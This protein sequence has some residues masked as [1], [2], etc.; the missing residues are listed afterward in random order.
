VHKTIKDMDKFK[1]TLPAMG[2]GIIEATITRWLVS[3]GERVAVDQPLLEVATDK[4]DSEI[5][6]PVEGTLSRLV[7][8]EGEIPKVGE[9][10]AIIETGNGIPKP[11][12]ELEDQPGGLIPEEMSDETFMKQ[13]VQSVENMIP[14][15]STAPREELFISPLVRMLA[16]Q[17]GITSQELREIR[18]T[19]M[20]GRVTRDDINEYL[21]HRKH[22][23]SEG[24]IFLP[25]DTSD[26]QQKSAIPDIIAEPGDETVEM[27]RMRKI[28]AGN[29]LKSKRV[30]PHVTSFL[31][32]DITALAE[33]RNRQKDHF[34]KKEQVKLTFTPIF[35]EAVAMALKEFPKIN[36]SLAGENIIIRKNINI[37]IA[38]ALPNGNLIVPV[39]K[40]ADRENLG[41]L[42][43]RI[44]D[45]AERARNNSLLL[46]EIKGGT[47]TITNIGQYNNLTGTPIIN[48]PESA[49][50][51]IGTMIKKP[52]AVQTP[53]GYGIAI[54]DITM[55]S[56]TYDHRV[57]DGAL[58]GGFLSRVAW[59]L[60][61]FD[62][63]REV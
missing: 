8:N 2:E 18:G 10:I 21:I 30:S 49:I 58:G 43:R 22:R 33:W 11:E 39:I 3:Q 14:V 45:L 36:V 55:L 23:E 57:I 35:V 29:M 60:E 25:L 38:T 34:L 59:H 54:R 37:G 24:R 13:I 31:E 63:R 12:E 4:V 47:F 16:Q 53:D 5:P 9:V 28:I 41:G 46:T 62:T 6:S 44:S 32:A 19:G 48:Q 51:A 50:L 61:H 26:E 17:R 7:Y 56:L 27:D 15:S 20:D 42:A 1:L 40:N 52:W